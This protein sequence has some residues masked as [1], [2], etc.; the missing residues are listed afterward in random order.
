MHSKISESPIFTGINPGEVAHILNLTHHQIKS[1]KPESIIAY[2]GDECK[3]LSIIIEGSVRGEITDINGKIIKIEDIYAPDAFA[4]AFLFASN[5][6]YLVDVVSNTQS[7]ILIIYKDDLLKLFQ[8]N[9]TILENYLKITSDRFVTITKKLKFIS[10]KTINGKLAH[11]FLQLAKENSSN[12]ITLPKSQHEL[13][14]YFGITRPSLA[15]S[16]RELDKEGY[17]K[18]RGKNIEIL[19]V[20][21]LLGKLDN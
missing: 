1:Y 8:S 7:K 14:E 19:N 21:K 20:K 18:A 3:S 2:S 12:T 13:S 11:Y 9:K 10:L 16:I 5:N 6:H 15:R 4:E 17:I